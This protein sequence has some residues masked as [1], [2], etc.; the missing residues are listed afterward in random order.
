[1][2]LF[3]ADWDNKET[4][5]IFINICRELEKRIVEAEMELTLAKSQGYLKNQLLQSGSSGKK[6]LAVIGIYTGFGGRLRR[7]IIRGSW[8]S[9]GELSS[10]PCNAILLTD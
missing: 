2:L 9:K 4:M 10:F 1:M 7:N 5:I 6:L 8:M 3:F